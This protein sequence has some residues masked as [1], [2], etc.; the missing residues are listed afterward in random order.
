MTSCFEPE[1]KICD[2]RRGSPNRKL[3]AASFRHPSWIWDRTGDY[4]NYHWRHSLAFDSEAGLSSRSL[5]IIGGKLWLLL[6]PSALSVVIGRV[7][8]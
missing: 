1:T 4:W 8:R 3:V 6:K 5:V 7:M 2:R